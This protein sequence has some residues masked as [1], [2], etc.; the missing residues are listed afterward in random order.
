MNNIENCCNKGKCSHCGNCCTDMIPITLNEYKLIKQ[1]I[2]E[3]NIKVFSEIFTVIDGQQSINLLCPFRDI[4]A[5]RCLI[6]PVRPNICRLFKCNQPEPIVL[7]HKENMHKKAYYNKIRNS[8]D[9]V[10]KL[11]SLREIF[12]DTSIDTIRALVGTILREYGSAD[13]KKIKDML[14]SFERPELADDDMIKQVLSEYSSFIKNK[15]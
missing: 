10:V 12:Y 3:H 15:V 4:K 6:Y 5:H 1:Y 8:K 9:T 11:Y 14:I 2:K 13:L 7:K